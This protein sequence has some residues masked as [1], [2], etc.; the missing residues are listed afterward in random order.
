MSVSPGDPNDVQ[1][2]ELAPQ[3]FL[4][5]R[6][7]LGR[8]I[9]AENFGLWKLVPT[10]TDAVSVRDLQF[11][12]DL[13]IDRFLLSTLTEE[14]AALATWR[15]SQ[16][17]HGSG[18]QVDD[19]VNRRAAVGHLGQVEAQI[20]LSDW[21]AERPS[22]S[23]ALAVAGWRR[24]SVTLATDLLHWARQSNPEDLRARHLS[25]WLGSPGYF[26]QT[27]LKV[28]AN[29]FPADQRSMRILAAEQRI[30]GELARASHP[31]V[32]VLFPG[33]PG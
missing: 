26:P 11:V 28:W 13:E 18:K 21:A 30:R 19:L 7:L 22:D 23:A 14:L 20:S 1:P 25:Y 27:R 29:R 4:D 17:E 31:L 5:S 15:S 33:E 9:W 12:F 16:P 8:D 6:P 10:S 3:L 32:E 24:S 2:P